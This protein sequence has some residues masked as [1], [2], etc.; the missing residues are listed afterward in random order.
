M[1]PTVSFKNEP[2]LKRPPKLSEQVAK[3]LGLE[4]KKGTLKPGDV[5]MSETEMASWFQV[6]RTV[7]REALARL[8]HDGILESRQGSK[9]RVAQ[10]D[11]NRVFRL[12]NLETEDLTEIAHLYELR[13][14]LESEAAALA[15]KRRS[16][17]DIVK[18]KHCLEA[19]EQAME[20]NLDGTA[21]DVAFHVSIVEASNNP[22]LSD[23]MRFLGNKIWN[24]IQED[25]N[26]NRP[27]VGLPPQV[28]K[29]H[30]AIFKAV[31]MGNPDEARKTV[32]AHVKN[33]AKRRGITIL[34]F[35]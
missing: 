27:E 12:D 2:K 11:T 17:E 20:E 5:L 9:C 16:Q 28:E 21:Q 23:F 7:I 29:E 30:V 14:I 10:F 15:A 32:L 6:S 26:R 34:D 4:I 13:A 22:F 25:W 19:L 1:L 35:K 8:K 18:L 3:F 31:S 33:G 24:I